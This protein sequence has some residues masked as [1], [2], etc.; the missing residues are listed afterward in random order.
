MAQSCTFRE[1]IEAIENNNEI[2]AG[3]WSDWEDIA[4]VEEVYGELV[5][6]DITYIEASAIIERAIKSKGA[7]LAKDLAEIQCRV[8]GQ[9]FAGSWWCR[10]REGNV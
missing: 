2:N 8:E 6:P 4:H 1:I 3:A 7:S 9:N 5:D 10:T